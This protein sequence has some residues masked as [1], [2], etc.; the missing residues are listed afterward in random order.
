MP[1]DAPIAGPLASPA[2][3]S[4][5]SSMPS[6]EIDRG[7]KA[8]TTEAG[9]RIPYDALIL[10]TARSPRAADVSAGQKGIHYLRTLDE[11]LALKAELHHGK[12][13]LV[14]G[15]GSG[16]LEIASSAADLASRPP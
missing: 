13:V 4:R 15:G 16:R 8:V 6:Q 7:A 14:V 2:R 3:A 10:A 11:A 9:E 1:Q 12:S 5:S